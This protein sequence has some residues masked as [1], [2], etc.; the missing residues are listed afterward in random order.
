MANNSKKKEYKA[1]KSAIRK[2][3][4][5]LGLVRDKKKAKAK[6]YDNYNVGQIRPVNNKETRGHNGYLITKN[7][8]GENA[9]F[10]YVSI[11][12]REKTNHKKNVKLVQN[13]NPSDNEKS[14]AVNKAKQAKAKE[15]GEQK[16]GWKFNKKDKKTLKNIFNKKKKK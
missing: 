13:P 6:K 5:V 11:T 8:S 15:L 9:E 14:Y 1:R 2:L 10:G 16:D 7:G 4:R 12:H 3:L